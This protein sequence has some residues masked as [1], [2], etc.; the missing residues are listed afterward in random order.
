VEVSYFSKRGGDAFIRRFFEQLGVSLDGVDTRG[1]DNPAISLKGY[2][3]RR[4]AFRYARERNLIYD[5]LSRAR[6]FAALDILDKS[7]VS[8]R[9]VIFSPDE[10]REILANADAEMRTLANMVSDAD[11]DTLLAELDP[12]RLAGASPRNIDREP[13]LSE[14]EVLS[15]MRVTADRLGPGLAV[16]AAASATLPRRA[17]PRA[18]RSRRR[19]SKAARRGRLSRLLMRLSHKLARF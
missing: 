5:R 14:E 10:R 19:I 16:D 6:F 11:R 18:S 9:L 12:A 13:L 4:I 1:D 17:V 3:V 2:W 8:E 15:M 7:L